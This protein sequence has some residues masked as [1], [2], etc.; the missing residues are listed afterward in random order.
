M[1]REI[2]NKWLNKQPLTEEE[3]LRL[4]DYFARTE[5]AAPTTNPL[6]GQTYISLG[7]NQNEINAMVEQAISSSAKQWF[8]RLSDITNQLGLQSAGEFRTGTGVPGDGFTGGRFGWP[9]F[10]YGADTYFLAGVENDVLQ[11]GLSLTDG[12]I[13]AGAGSVVLDDSG[14]VATAGTIGGWTIGATSL[15]DALG[16]VGISSAVT[17]GDDIRI[18]AGGADPT[19]ALFQVY[20]SGFLYA[21]D[22]EITGTITAQTGVIGGWFINTDRFES[23]T[24]LVGITLNSGVSMVSV[25]DQNIS[26][27]HIQI[28]GAN[29]RIR[30]SNFVTGSAGF[31]IAADT[32]DAEFN[33][34][35]ARGELKTFLFSSSNQMAVA[36]NIVVSKNAGKLGADVT[37]IA[38]TVNFGQ[39]MTVGDWIKIQGPDSAGSNALE[40]MLIGSL[41][42]GTTYNVTRNVDGSGANA[43]KKDTPFV[44]IG[45]SGDSRIE[46][47][48]GASGSIQLIT[49]GAAYGTTTTQ[50][51]MST[52]AG[53]ITAG[54]GNVLINASGIT[55]ANSASSWF[56]FKDAG[57]NAN[58]INIAATPSNTLEI[59]NIAT[60]GGAGTIAFYIKDTAGVTRRPLQ[61]LEDAGNANVLHALVNVGSAGSKFSIGSEVVIWA[62]KTGTTTVFNEAGLDID[63]RVESDTNANFFLLDASAENLFIGGRVDFRDS[64]NVTQHII[65]PTT[66]SFN[67]ANADID[68]VV[69]G[70]TQDGVFVVDAGLNRVE[71]GTT[72]EAVHV[73]DPTTTTYFNEPGNDLDFVV[74]GDTDTS[75]LYVD[76]GLDAIGIGG[77]ASGSY[78]LQV[79]GSINAT[80]SYYQAGTLTRHPVAETNANDIFQVTNPGGA[81]LWTGTISGA[82]SGTSVTVSA[83]LTGTEAVLVPTSTSQLGKMR[84]YNTTRG[85]SA[86]ISN[87]NTG[88]NVVTLTATVPAAWA[89]G[90]SL[91]VASQTVSGGGVN[92]VDIEITSGPTGKTS[93]FLNMVISS[94]TVGDTQRVHPTETFGAGKIMAQVALVA[95]QNS[96]RLAL[97]PIASNLFSLSWTGTP[98]AVL[99]REAGYI[100]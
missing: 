27:T 48:A 79:T 88:T 53:A 74:R 14:I 97:L 36:G 47:T 78:K 42:S 49:Q 21:E 80:G 63:F 55:M 8:P 83:P 92:W 3:Q 60:S 51:S 30:S 67:E 56:N 99:V 54:A 39:A 96:N 90:D 24:A 28:D 71:I 17:G 57:G 18:W 26:A 10:T 72:T 2:A 69:H 45:Q 16:E 31:N 15:T 20:E 98:T 7:P 87:Y 65:A 4:L 38:T 1:I 85:T 64:S 19:T 23:L 68:F 35:T 52:V 75:L 73:I 84:L 11:V 76:A 66:V 34:I 37:A 82:P 58:T 95:N 89:N 9:G 44:V 13:Y 6:T 41:V 46:L 33:N 5:S 81:S 40:A 77:A 100:N 62:G 91:T 25:G 32:G 61:L 93:L 29:Q 22:V 12:K 86:L 94:A 70:D 43:W 59:T 50:A